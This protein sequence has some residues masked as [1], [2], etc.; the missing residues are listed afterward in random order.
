MWRRGYLCGSP[1]QS[2]ILYIPP[3]IERLP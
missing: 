3:A 2:I 1:A